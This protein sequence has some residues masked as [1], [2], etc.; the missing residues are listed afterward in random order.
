MKLQ[1]L[2]NAT[3]EE[4]KALINVETKE[5]IMKG[6]YYHDKINY[7][8]KGYLDGLKSMNIKYELLEELEVTPEMDLFNICDFYNDN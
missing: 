2:Y 5:I 7:Q 1:I 3:L 4:E 8:I 6:D